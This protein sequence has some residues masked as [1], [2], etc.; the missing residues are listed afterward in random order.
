MDVLM[1]EST[2]SDNC[3]I[4]PACEMFRMHLVRRIFYCSKPYCR[5]WQIGMDHFRELKEMVG[6]EG[7][8]LSTSAKRINAGLGSNEF[9]RCDT[10]CFTQY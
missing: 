5:G 1:V 6:R 4:L 7:N 2:R 10:R 3:R 9:V 8:V